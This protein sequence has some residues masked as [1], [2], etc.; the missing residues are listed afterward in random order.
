M[1][2]DMFPIEIF[3]HARVSQ[4]K[5]EIHAR[6]QILHASRQRLLRVLES[7]EA[8]AIECHDGHIVFANDKWTLAEY[9]VQHDSIVSCVM[10][11]AE[12]P[13]EFAGRAV[14]TL[15]V[16]DETS[17]PHS[18]CI[19]PNGNV[20]VSTDDG[21]VICI[22]ARS[23]AVLARHGSAQGSAR[24]QLHFPRGVCMSPDGALLF[25]ADQF[26]DRVQAF[27]SLSSSSA[28]AVRSFGTHG[29]RDNELVCP[30][31]VAYCDSDA[32]IY[33]CDAGNNRIVVLGACT[34]YI[35]LTPVPSHVTFSHN[36]HA[37][38]ST[39]QP[40][41]ISAWCV[42]SGNAVAATQNSI[43]LSQWQRRV[44]TRSRCVSLSP[45]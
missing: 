25:V 27:R 21:G 15:V 28:A 44:S 1:S 13:A 24:N 18:V 11:D 43:I 37:A 29:S 8:A 36:S 42:T 45:T 22:E 7:Q 16:V 20:W 39:L 3:A 38:S 30:E 6:N 12:K 5:S 34:T 23:G 32:C 31:G 40:P 9:G 35:F 14:R 10:L 33:T 17:T 26:N 19:A 41:R 2:G 4:L